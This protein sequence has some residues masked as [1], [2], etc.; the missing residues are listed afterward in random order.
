MAEQKKIGRDPDSLKVSVHMW[1][2][3]APGPGQARIDRLGA[4][5]ELG[6]S[7]VMTLRRDSADSDEPLQRLAEEARAAGVDL[8]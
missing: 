4:F 2:G 7:R 3:D 5:R 1:W 6:V 8:A